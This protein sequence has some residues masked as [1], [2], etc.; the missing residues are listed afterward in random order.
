M[1]NSILVIIGTVIGAGFA[2]GKEIFTFFNVYGIWG[3]L[4]LM[5]SEVI[6]GF[7][8]YKTFYIVINFDINTYSDLIGKTITKSKFMNNVICN[9]VNIF[10]LISFIVMVAGFSAYF[11]QELNASYLFGAILISLLCFF[12]FLRNIDGIVKINK[13]FIPFLIFII[14]LLGFKNMN[15]I[16]Y[17]KFNS[18]MASLNWL[19]SAILYASYNLIILLPILISLKKYVRNIKMAKLISTFATFFLLIMAMVLFFLLNYYFIDIE[20]VELPTVYIA[21]SLGRTFQ[22]VCGS[23]ILV[24]IFTTAISSGYGFLNNFHFSSKKTYSLMAAVICVLGISFSNIGFSNLLNLLY[25]VLGM[26]GFLQIVF[27][28]FFHKKP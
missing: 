26:L 27:I 28:L 2:S 12:T 21:S 7:V 8:I 9:I 15:C 24:A 10:L 14:L 3:A 4:G 17:Y 20:H 19:I 11:T 16:T 6:I 5:L 13:Y 25:P 22:Y 1:I 18:S 23:V